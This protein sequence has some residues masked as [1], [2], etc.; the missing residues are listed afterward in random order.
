MPAEPFIIYFLMAGLVLAQLFIL[1]DMT[2]PRKPP[3]EFNFVA[4]PCVR[5]DVLTT[6]LVKQ[7]DTPCLTCEHFS[8]TFGER[9][10]PMCMAWRSILDTYPCSDYQPNK[11]GDSN[12]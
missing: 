5:C 2:R 4:S 10:T 7:K 3:P 8:M 1:R 12:A 6:I 11:K 9:N